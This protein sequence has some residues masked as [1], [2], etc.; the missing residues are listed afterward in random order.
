MLPRPEYAITAN[1]ISQHVRDVNFY[2]ACSEGI[3]ESVASFVSEHNPGQGI[4]QYGLEEASFGNQPAA[5]EYLLQYGA[6][7]HSCAFERSCPVGQP[8]STEKQEEVCSL[9][10]SRARDVLPLLQAFVD[11]GWH[12]NQA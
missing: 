7:L 3:L 4:L 2:A 8:G 9:D 10:A 6:L 1:L 5:A 12:P 11:S